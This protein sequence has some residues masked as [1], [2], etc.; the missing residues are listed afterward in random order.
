MN[1]FIPMF[2]LWKMVYFTEKFFFL[3]KD[4]F[5]INFSTGKNWEKCYIFM[6]QL[7]F[8]FLAKNHGHHHTTAS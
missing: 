8:C 6:S 5:F 2:P 4:I 7:T 1:H 3:K